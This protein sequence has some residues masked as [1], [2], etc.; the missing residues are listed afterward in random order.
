MRILSFFR[1]LR[2]KL[3]LTYTAVTVLALLAL[4]LI[5]LV[6]FFVLSFGT[7]NDINSYLSDVISI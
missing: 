5:A 1:T 6:I 4:E 3:I 7:N 2:G